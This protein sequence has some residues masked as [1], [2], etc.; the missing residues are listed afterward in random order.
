[1]LLLGLVRLSSARAPL[2]MRANIAL[3]VARGNG[4]AVVSADVRCV[5]GSLRY[6]G[7]SVER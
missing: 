5:V 1:M 7:V 3:L 4:A 6:S 2:L